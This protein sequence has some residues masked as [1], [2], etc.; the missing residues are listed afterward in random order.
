MSLVRKLS[1]AG[2]LAAVLAGGLLATAGPAAARTVPGAQ[3]GAQAAGGPLAAA[4][5]CECGWPST[6]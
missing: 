3:A 2:L 5:T 4:P 1:A 6:D